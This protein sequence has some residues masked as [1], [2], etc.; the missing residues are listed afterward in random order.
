MPTYLADLLKKID[1]RIVDIGISPGYRIP[2]RSVVPN[3]EVLV[4]DP[5]ESVLT[6]QINQAVL[7]ELSLVSSPNYAGT[8]VE[9]RHDLEGEDT[10]NQLKR[11][12]LWL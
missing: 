2:P 10:N 9:L 3:A 12:Y 1:G 5:G 8:E 4:Q 11:F 7:K 6:R